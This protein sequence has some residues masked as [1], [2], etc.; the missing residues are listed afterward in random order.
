[1]NHKHYEETYYDYGKYINLNGMTP[2]QIVDRM[3]NE[4][5]KKNKV[6]INGV[7]TLGTD[8][9]WYIIFTPNVPLNDII[10]MSITIDEKTQTIEMTPSDT[11]ITY[12][13]V[14]KYCTPIITISPSTTKTTRYYVNFINDNGDGRFNININEYGDDEV[15]NTKQI[16]QKFG[17]ETTVHVADIEGHDFVKWELQIGE[18]F[19]S[20]N[21]ADVVFIMPEDNVSLKCYYLVQ[22]FTVTWLNKNGD[23]LETDIE[24]P[25]GTT[26]TYNGETPSL[27]DTQEYNFI[28]NGWSP[29]IVDVT[30]DITYTASFKEDKKKYTITWDNDG[31]IDTTIVEYGIIPTH[32]TPIK[33]GNAQFTYEFNGWEPNITEV[34]GDTRYTATYNTFTKQYNITWK[35]WNGTTLT[36]TTVNYGELPVYP[37]EDPIKQGNTQYT[38]IFNGW[39][40][41]ITEVTGNKTY[42]ANFQQLI[43][44]YPLFINVNNGEINN[45]QIVSGSSINTEEGVEYN[46]GTTLNVELKANEGYSIEGGRNNTILKT[47]K[48][49]KITGDTTIDFTFNIKTYNITWKDW[50]NS[51]LASTTVNYDELPV[52][53]NQNPTRPSNAENTYI[54]NDWEPEVTNATEDTTYKAVYDSRINTYTVTWL[55]SDGSLLETDSNV[56][57]GTKPSYDGTTPTIEKEHYICEFIGWD[58]SLNEGITG[59]TVYT[60]IY[61]ETPIQYNLTVSVI[62]GDYEITPKKT[63]YTYGEIVKITIIPETGYEYEELEE[64]IEVTGDI[65]I[66]YECTAIN[67]DLT[68][69]DENNEIKYEVLCP[70]NSDITSYLQYEEKEGMMHKWMDGQIEFKDKTMP[71]RDLTLRSV[72]T[73]IPDSINVMYYNNV[74]VENIDTI[75][76][77][78][79]IELLQNTTFEDNQEKTIEVVIPI[80]NNEEAWIAHDEAVIFGEEEAWNDIYGCKYYIA[81]PKNKNVLVTDAISTVTMT[82]QDKTMIIEGYEFDIYLSQSMQPGMPNSNTSHQ[83]KIKVY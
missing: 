42:K 72:Y 8:N 31:V 12:G 9:M 58:K 41:N 52:Y 7:V 55:N 22:K 44:H 18:T 24:V 63:T 80:L 50:N 40:P 54:F 23:V 73:E 4:G 62:R 32:A 66:R 39:E 36:S 47:F 27:E 1:M 74:L 48:N 28:F 26:P 29:S 38:Y 69:I 53:P 57:Y 46:Y 13:P 15:I 65:E 25:Y 49:I 35:N 59:N 68:I 64:I 77:D 5:S 16:K 71:N 61:S 79:A 2:G 11:E 56:N 6:T 30:S 67:Y 43:N 33:Q 19:E 10:K 60:A 75:N 78:N 45:I 21:T 51:T 81:I 3:K 20:G 70:F 17:E 34:T 14:D 82:K 37:N 76:G 83:L